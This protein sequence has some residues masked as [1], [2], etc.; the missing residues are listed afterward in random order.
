M[1]K[2]LD[3]WSG[4]TATVL[5]F[6]GAAAPEGWLLC[7]GQAV[8]RSTYPNLF[9]V[10]CPSMGTVTITIASPGVVTLN[11]HGKVAGDRIRLSTTGALPTGLTANTD[12]YLVSV[13]TN[14]FSLATSAGG[15]PIN[16]TG[17]QSGI[18]AAQYFPHGAGDGSTTFNVPDLRGEFIRGIDGVRGI[19]SSRALGSKQK[20]SMVALDSSGVNQSYLMQ[21]NSAQIASPGDVALSRERLG[22]DYDGTTYP[23]TFI[24]WLN[25]T[26]DQTPE[27]GG[28]YSAQSRPRNVAMNHIIKT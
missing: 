22:L 5:P 14:T 19:D 3:L 24:S 12:Y 28:F 10:L 15:T 11:A 27:T 7:S 23:N 9:T 1:S 17:S 2:V 16:T 6:A 4:M 13:G 18:H 21:A 20:G 26:N 25:T 8:S